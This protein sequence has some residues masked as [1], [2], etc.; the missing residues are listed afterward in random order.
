M[1]KTKKGKSNVKVAIHE[2]AS[3][4]HEIG[5]IDKKTMCRLAASINSGPP[6]PIED[7][8]KKIRRQHLKKMKAQHDKEKGALQKS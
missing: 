5:L 1:T 7:A 8:F 3:D 4:L 2:T 6:A